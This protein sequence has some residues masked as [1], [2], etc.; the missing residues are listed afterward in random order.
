MFMESLSFILRGLLCDA[1]NVVLEENGL[2]GGRLQNLFL[3]YL[4]YGSQTYIIR[5][6]I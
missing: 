6:G 4:T 1:E 3:Q 5:R 2:Q